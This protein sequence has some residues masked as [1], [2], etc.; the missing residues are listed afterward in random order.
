MVLYETEVKAGV[1]DPDYTG[2][3]G[4]VLKNNPKEPLE[5]LIGQPI[6]Q[7][8]FIKF[9]TPQLVQVPSLTRTQRGNHGFGA[10]SASR[11]STVKAF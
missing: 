2:N 5:R 6:A 4:V 9:A 10:H 8:L 1:I 3:M 11:A 7:L